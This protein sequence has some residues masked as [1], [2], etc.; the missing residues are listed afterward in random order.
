MLSFFFNIEIKRGNGRLCRRAVLTA[1]VRKLDFRTSP[2]T[3]LSLFHRWWWIDVCFE[4]SLQTRRTL[5]ENVREPQHSVGLPEEK[6][7]L[8]RTN[9][10]EIGHIIIAG[11][12]DAIFRIEQWVLSV[13]ES[14]DKFL[15]NLW[16]IYFLW[17]SLSFLYVF[18]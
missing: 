11:I 8:K 14:C 9:N 15:L 13:C 3:I 6:F 17:L 18:F 1:A 10:E 7:G 16:Y 12:V 2:H 4:L 5:F